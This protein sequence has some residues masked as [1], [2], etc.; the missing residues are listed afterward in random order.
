MNLL[1]R[2]ICIGISLFASSCSD[3]KQAGIRDAN[4]DFE[5]GIMQLE[6]YGLRM[7][8]D[9]Y[10]E[11]LRQQGITMNTVAGCMVDDEILEHAE[12]YNE[13]MKRLINRK[14]NKDVFQEAEEFAKKK[15]ASNKEKSEEQ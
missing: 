4:R 15:N 11:E 10:E 3:Y 6:I 5:K 1:V 7:A 12:G 13:T 8:N 9:P 14:L 2:Y